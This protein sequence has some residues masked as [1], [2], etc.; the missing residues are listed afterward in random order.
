[1]IV[2]LLVSVYTTYKA[3]VAGNWDAVQQ[4]RRVDG[5]DGQITEESGEVFGGVLRA[6]REI[7]PILCVEVGR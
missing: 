5:F 3:G 7:A 2:E 1:L 6:R 4:N